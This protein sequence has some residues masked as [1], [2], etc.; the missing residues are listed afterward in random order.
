MACTQ[1]ENFYFAIRKDTGTSVHISQM[2][3]KDRGLACNCV[4]AACN[5]PLVAKLGRGKRVRH[6]AHY[7]ERDIVLDCSAQKA[8]ESGLHQMAKEIVKESAYINLPEIQISARRDLSRNEDDWEQLQPLILEKK[9][10]LQF[11]NAETEVRCDG[12]VPDIYIPIRDSVLLVEIAV[13]HYVDIEKYNRIKRAKVPAIEIDISDFLKNTESFSE[14]ELRKELLDSVEHKRWIY[15]RREQEGIQKL[16]ARN[17]KRELEYQAKCKR[18]QE[19]REQ[20]EKWIE[21]QK[22]HEQQTLELFDKLEENDTYYLAFSR[23]LVNSEQALNEINKLGICS[24]QFSNAEDIP[25]YLNIPVFGEVAFNCDRRI[26]QTILFENF[27]YRRKENSVLQ[28]DKVYFYFGNVQKHRLNLDFVHFWKKK[29][30]EKSLLRCALEEYMVHLS[31]LG[32]IDRAFYQYAIVDREYSIRRYTLEPENTLYAEF[33]K[34]A[35]A[36][37]PPTNNPF[38][39]LQEGWIKKCYELKQQGFSLE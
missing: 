5:R 27:I 20:Q 37:M 4:C 15:H 13:T 39:Y 24:L 14:D 3:E 7:A 12:F 28:P 2:L 6:F 38:G 26:W 32:F 22:L 30:P 8:N 34:Q 21:E 31:G 18:E 1:T 33:L 29:F 17:Q 36:Q 19:Q 25:F 11:S 23:K 10:K 9:R 35:L 16:R